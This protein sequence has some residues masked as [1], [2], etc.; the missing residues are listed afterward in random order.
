MNKRREAYLETLRQDYLLMFC[1]VTQR[2]TQEEKKK[3]AGLGV[4]L[5][6]SAE[7]R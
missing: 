2:Q 4:I 1:V 7:Q 3:E 5:L 6:L